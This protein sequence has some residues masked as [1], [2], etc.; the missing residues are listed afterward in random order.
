MLRQ[1]WGSEPRS[2]IFREEG[3]RSRQPGDFTEPAFG[4][5]YDTRRANFSFV[6]PEP[7]YGPV[8]FCR[9]NACT[10]R[11]GLN[12]ID[13][14][15]Q[16]CG[17]EATSRVIQERAG[18]TQPPWFEYGCEFAAI[19]L[20]RSRKSS[21]SVSLPHMRRHPKM[22][23]SQSAIQMAASLPRPQPSLATACPNGL[24]PRTSLAISASVALAPGIS[25]PRITTA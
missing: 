3:A 7:G 21:S 16:R 19:C 1:R 23:C 11:R 12:E 6:E 13:E 15:P 24:Q 5:R 4:R 14:G 18:K 8:P 20:R 2:S 10:I 9:H 25:A 22:T 17:D